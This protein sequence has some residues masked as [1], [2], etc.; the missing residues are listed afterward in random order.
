MSLKPFSRDRLRPAFGSGELIGEVGRIGASRSSAAS[1]EG[2]SAR[3]TGRG[4]ALP[5]TPRVL[6]GERGAVVPSSESCPRGSRENGGS[7]PPGCASDPS[8][9]GEEAAQVAQGAPRYPAGT[10]PLS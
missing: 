7:P 4:S 3:A 2:A 8:T 5:G 1:P 9:N 10:A 6:D